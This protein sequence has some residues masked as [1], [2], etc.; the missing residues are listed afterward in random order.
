MSLIVLHSLC[1]QVMYAVVDFGMKSKE[2]GETCNGYRHTFHFYS[3][4]V[5]AGCVRV[6]ESKQRRARL[7]SGCVT[8][9]LDSWVTRQ[10]FQ[11]SFL[12]EIL[13]LHQIHV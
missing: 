6:F 3:L 5:E 2:K 10:A 1:P 12:C 13:L 11:Y 8:A 4:S 7:V 9:C